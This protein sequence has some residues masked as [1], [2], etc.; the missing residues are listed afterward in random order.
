MIDYADKTWIQERGSRLTPERGLLHWSYRPSA[1]EGV[2][3]E[4]QER[5]DRAWDRTREM[6]RHG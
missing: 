5:S 3:K 2:D 6:G 4:Y 1:K